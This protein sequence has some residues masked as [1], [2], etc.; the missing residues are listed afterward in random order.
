MSI[1]IISIIV[2]IKFFRIILFTN[3][4]MLIYISIILNTIYRV[5]IKVRTSLRNPIIRNNNSRTLSI[6]KETNYFHYTN[7][8][9]TF[10]WNTI[11]N[12]SIKTSSLKFF[13]K[14]FFALFISTISILSKAKITSRK[15]Y[16]NITFSF[17]MFFS[18]R[19]I[20]KSFRCS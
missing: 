3:I 8:L 11:T 20:T 9:F 19:M 2:N 12:K 6:I 15:H 7:R 17:W 14:F 13:K 5:N 1:Y 18:C 10:S 4:T 16:F